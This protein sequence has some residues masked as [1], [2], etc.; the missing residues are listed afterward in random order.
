MRRK[1]M[2]RSTN[3]FRVLIRTLLHAGII[4]ERTREVYARWVDM[5]ELRGEGNVSVAA[6]VTDA[7]LDELR[8]INRDRQRLGR[9]ASAAVP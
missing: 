5:E 6:D 2:R 7:A 3:A 1:A 4:T 9:R 8:E